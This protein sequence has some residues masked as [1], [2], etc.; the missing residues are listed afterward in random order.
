[1]GHIYNGLG[2]FRTR[3]N[4][5]LCLQFI[6]DLLTKN[7][8][9]GKILADVLIKATPASSGIYLLKNLMHQPQSEVTINASSIPK[10]GV[11]RLTDG[12]FIEKLQI[13]MK[14]QI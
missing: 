6:W 5:E 2:Q 12:G 1:M 13:K 10:G 9:V 11:R 14:T 4:S 7:A 8:L 3:L